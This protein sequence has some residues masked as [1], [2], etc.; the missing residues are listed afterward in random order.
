MSSSISILPKTGA[1]FE[2][3][4]WAEFAAAND[5]YRSGE[6]RYGG[7]EYQKPVTLGMDDLYLSVRFHPE[8]IYLDVPWMSSLLVHNAAFALKILAAF[9]GSTYECAPEY[10]CYM[11]GGDQPLGSDY[12]MTYRRLVAPEDMNPANRLFGGRIM[13]WADEAVALYAMCQMKTKSIVT[14]KV[15]EILFKNPAWSG[16]VLEFFVKNKKVGKTSLQ[17]ECIV[18][19]KTIPRPPIELHS[20]I[21]QCDFT[22]VAID[23]DGR[24]RPHGMKTE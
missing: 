6:N 20:V 16:D 11:D 4:A 22:F 7:V 21:L 3:K 14:L 2:H 18:K 13:Q 12:F 17:I 15:S 19:R 9:P 1:P 5:L 24:T 10:N 8:R 23:K